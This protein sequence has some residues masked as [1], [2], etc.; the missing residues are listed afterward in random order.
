MADAKRGAAIEYSAN[1]MKD[2]PMASGEV[3][4][5]QHP[6]KIS[7]AIFNGIRCYCPNCG[8]GE[9]YQ[10]FVNVNASCNQCGEEFH[11][12]RADDLPAYLNIFV[13]GH[14]VVGALMISLKYELFGMWPTAIGGSMLAFGLAVAL[15][16]PIKGMVIALQWALGMHGF[17]TKNA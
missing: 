7:K 6:R 13:V 15:M 14:I 5:T 10:N 4:N 8:E 2:R 11:H 17:E 3:S 16:R 1:S 12:H 9:L